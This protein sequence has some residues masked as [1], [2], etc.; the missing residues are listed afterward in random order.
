MYLFPP[1]SSFHLPT[2]ERRSIQYAFHMLAFIGAGQ[3][4]AQKKADS[5]ADSTA[6]TH[7][8]FVASG[9]Q[10]DINTLVNVRV[11]QP[12]Y[13][14][15]V[16]CG[17]SGVGKSSLVWAGLVPA[18]A[19]KQLRDR[20]ALPVVMRIYSD[21][22]AALGEALYA[23]LAAY[24]EAR[25]EETPISVEQLKAQLQCNAKHHL[26]TVLI[27]DQFEEFF[28]ICKQPAQ[29]RTFY[30]FLRDCLVGTDIPFVKVIFSL[31]EDYL[32]ELLE[33]ED[34]VKDLRL[35]FLSREQRQRIENFTP[36]I[37]RSVITEL[38]Q[39]TTLR[40]DVDLVE[41]LVQGLTNELGRVRPVE[42]QVV[43][44]QLEAEGITTL[45][46]YRR[47]GEQPKLVLA[48]RWVGA[49]VE[50]CGPENADAAWQVLVALTQENGTRPLL[51]MGELAAA[52]ADYQRLLGTR[53]V[54]LTGDILPILVGSGLVVRWPQEPED[55]FQLVHDYLLEPIRR[56]YNADYRQQLE[57]L[58]REKQ[59][60][61]EKRR[62]EEERRKR[63][64]RWTLWGALGA[65]V[66]FA[67]LA[68][69]AGRLAY[70]SN[71]AEQVAVAR[72]LLA[73]AEGMLSREPSLRPAATLL[74]VEV[75]KRFQRLNHP[76]LEVDP[77]L[78]QRFE[79]L[80]A[81]IKRVGHK[82]S[83]SSASFSPDSQYLATSS[84]DGTAKLIEV[85]SGRE[86][87]TIE[88][89]TSVSSVSFSPDSQ[90]LATGSMDGAVKVI[91]VIGG[92]EIKTL[93]LGTNIK[94]ISFSADSQY[95]AIMGVWRIAKL[96][97]LASGCEIKTIKH[98]GILW[99]ISFS[100]DSQYLATNSSDGTAKLI[101]VA[102]GQ[103]ISTI[104]HKAPIHRVVRF[105]PDSQ[106]LVTNS[107]DGTVKLIEVA[108]GREINT[109]YHKTPI[110]GVVR[111]SPDSQYL[112]T[113]SD[114][115]TVKLIEVASGQEINAIEHEVYVESI[116]FSKNSRYLVIRS[117]EGIVQ[118]VEMVGGREI[119]IIGQE[120]NVDGISFT[121]DSQELF[122]A[123]SQISANNQYRVIYNS[124]ES[125]VQLIEVSSGRELKTIEH[126]DSITSV[127]FSGDSQYLA[128][129]SI[130]GTAQLIR[131]T[132]GGPEINT[133][134]HIK[135][136]NDTGIIFSD[137]S[138]YLA[139]RG[140]DNTVKLIEVVSGLEI[141]SIEHADDVISIAFS[142]DSQYLATRSK[143]RTAQ[144]IEVVSGRKI[145]TI[146]HHGVPWD[147]SFSNDNQYLAT[148]SGDG[149]VKLIE[150][151]SG[152]EITTIYHK[153][154]VDGVFSGDSQ[155]I[156]TSSR[157]GTVKLIEVSSGREITTIYHKDKANNVFS[158]D[159]QYLVTNS[160]DGT[161]K[162]IKVAS[163]QEINTIYHDAPIRGVVRFSPDSQ[164]LATNS[165]D[166]TVKLIEAASGR[167][168]NTIEHEVYVAS[169]SF[170]ENSQYLVIS[171]W[172]ALKFF[173]VVSGRE[174][175][176]I[177]EINTI[178]DVDSVSLSA[179]KTYRVSQFE[180][181]ITLTE[182]ASSRQFKI[183]H[184][185]D[186]LDFSFSADNQYFAASSSD[187]TA[188][189]IQL[190][191]LE[192]IATIVHDGAIERVV[193]SPDSQN[194]LTLSDKVIR[195][196]SVTTTA[197]IAA[198]ICTRMQQNLS[199]EIWK[200]YIGP[201]DTYTKTCPEAPIHPS[202]FTE[203]SATNMTVDNARLLLK[204]IKTIAPEADLYPNTPE[205]E[206]DI[207]IALQK[208]LDTYE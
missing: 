153:D 65:V 130:D 141:S 159:S 91:E 39:R 108:S 23:A 31:R 62:E 87:K 162:L 30:D 96:I 71:R 88:H 8:S 117:R 56:R 84:A 144:L 182:V 28:F 113:S 186:V 103:E 70:Q 120:V 15:T 32:H 187:Q 18:L 179:Q 161:V 51:T 92:R 174:I 76:T 170:S 13:K 25:L 1:N 36:S 68:G 172:D 208:W 9:R 112:A 100:P 157:D 98:N 119:N 60:A 37:A 80:P 21:W 81:L 61:E 206:R 20:R 137:N 195:I 16:L 168:L 178:G 189:L 44:A 125:I 104:Y 49:V 26:L 160:R 45:G 72:Q 122:S 43:G 57:Q 4:Q 5:T 107:S 41:A 86:I 121:E 181:S 192:Q 83:V 150:V 40:L 116:S 142:N 196:N 149:S 134:E 99:G 143:D 95:L 133:I 22:D 2:P 64:Q 102:S 105:S 38:S 171:S 147:M 69:Y 166:G 126:E 183:K 124:W 78:R 85:A 67:S 7:A 140:G 3:L 177:E 136:N 202:L 184:E 146:E 106:Y 114:V 111:F 6:E 123:D 185:D 97:K 17:L 199:A 24:P 180:R 33:F 151:S 167:E 34:F 128:T 66:V 14:L 82:S 194:L 127:S 173:D 29:R 132:S 42:L 197:E 74:A 89:D 59:Q 55:R 12:R 156:S 75:F 138:Q 48:E 152:R 158:P 154:N 204:R 79:R 93:E 200:L 54:S 163:G 10:E 109:I 176:T 115:G 129:S 90:Y 19:G 148:E 191:T 190:S 203:I 193:F 50:D 52:L 73:Q 131:M 188:K 175:N 135:P 35:D 53:E 58:V 47:L 118:V 110:H 11:S 165:R 145:T 155:Y 77:L 169:V 27:F 139:V 201:L 46:Q 205:I 164:Y 198:E 207:D 94:S 63:W 101:E